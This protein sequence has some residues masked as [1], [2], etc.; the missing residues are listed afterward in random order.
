MDENIEIKEDVEVVEEIEN[1]E[2]NAKEATEEI[3]EENVQ[4]KKDE[5]D[6]ILEKI[7][8]MSEAVELHSNVKK[9]VSENGETSG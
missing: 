2:K 3:V 5:F 9:A 6:G 8:K 1:L 7:K 4:N